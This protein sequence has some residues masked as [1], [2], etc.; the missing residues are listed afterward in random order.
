MYTST[1]K[2][3]CNAAQA[4]FILVGMQHILVALWSSKTSMRNFLYGF[5]RYARMR[6]DWILDLRSADDLAFAPTADKVR[7]GAYTGIVADEET[8]LAHPGIVSCRETAVV[9]YATYN[10]A[11]FQRG[12]KLVF[13]QHDNA[14]TGAFAADY[15]VKLGRFASYGYVPTTPDIPFSTARARGFAARLAQHGHHCQTYGRTEPLDVFL[16][17]L[18]KP[19]AVMGACDRVA[20]DVLETCRA[21]R[22]DVPSRIAVLGVDNDELIC[23]FARPSLTSICRDDVH[24]L[25]F[26]AG[27]ALHSLLKGNGRQDQTPR[28]IEYNGMTVVERESCA[29]LP[30]AVHIAMTAMEFIRKNAKR[31]LHVSDVVAHLHVSRRLADK[32]FRE[33]HGKSILEAI[34]ECRLEEVAR[35]LVMSRLP[36]GKIAA[37]CGFANLAYLGKLFRRRYGVTM[38]GW[39][40]ETM[41]GHAER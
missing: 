9:L 21:I 41:A 39:R 32:R 22:I 38:G 23:E 2:H 13:A 5:A 3:A 4:W 30:P 29:F 35:R 31:R 1:F 10:P 16:Q 11:L 6:K 28:L 36:I 8:F 26:R 18:P 20:L 37:Q 12:Q 33:I 19:A 34:T 25:G 14:V 40:H 15:L 27:K 7:S 24:E 17:K